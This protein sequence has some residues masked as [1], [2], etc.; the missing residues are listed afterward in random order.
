[1]TEPVSH[2]PDVSGLTIGM[3]GGTGHQGR[4]LAY[5]FALAGLPVLLGSRDAA[6]A[7]LVAQ[8]IGLG[9]RGLANADCS[10][11]SDI[12]LVAVPWDAHEPTLRSLQRELVG[13]VVVDCVNPIGFDARGA[14]ALSVP[15]G[16]A[17]EQACSLLPESRVVGAFHHVSAKLLA[18][19]SIEQLDLDILVVGDDREATDLVQALAGQVAGLRGVY[20]GRLRNAHQ[21]EALTANL[22]SINRRYKAHAGV[23]ITDV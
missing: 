21:I 17:T 11:G 12:V 7:E 22:I 23:R 6:R 5:R 8:E 9:V 4:G 1:M 3:L 13:K 14:Y 20:A 18:D 16:S 2:S 15:E 19:P 10:L